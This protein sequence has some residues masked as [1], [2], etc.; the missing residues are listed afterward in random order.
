MKKN[1]AQTFEVCTPLF[2]K[3]HMTKKRL[4]LIFNGTT[5]GHSCGFS[6]GFIG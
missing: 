4:F 1:D 6:N 2:E 5:Y 3:K